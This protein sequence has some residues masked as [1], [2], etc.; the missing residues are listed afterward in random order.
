MAKPRWFRFSLRTLFVLFTVLAVWLGWNAQHVHERK[1]ILA[2]I[3]RLQ[4]TGTRY[5][6][7]ETL[8]DNPQFTFPAGSQ[9]PALVRVP[10]IRRLFGDETCLYLGVPGPLDPRLVERMELAFPEA[11]LALYLPGDDAVRDSLYLPANVRRENRGTIFK[12]G[13]IEK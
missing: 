7:L 1:A 6:C 13:L 11:Q 4:A 5:L 10:S 8:E 12:T 3:T 9:D 2:E